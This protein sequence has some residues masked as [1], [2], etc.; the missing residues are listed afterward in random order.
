MTDPVLDRIVALQAASGNR[1]V[2]R[3]LRAGEG[4]AVPGL[5]PTSPTSSSGLPPSLNLPADYA[6]RRQAEAEA[7]IREYLDK[8]KPRVEGQIIIGASVA[9]LVDLMRRNVPEAREL[10][11]E[12]I[13]QC[14]RRYFAPLTIAEHRKPGDKEGADKELVAALRNA[15]SKIPTEL[16]IERAHGWAKVTM[17]GYEVGIRNKDLEA[18]AEVGWDKSFGGH[19]TVGNVKFAAKVSPPEEAGGPM[20]WEAQVT[21]P[22]ADDPVPIA[23][24]LSEVVSRAEK[25]THEAADRARRSGVPSM[26]ELS[27]LFSPVKEA[28]G[29]LSAIAGVSGP[30]VGVKIEGEGPKISVQATL[31]FTF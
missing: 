17:S 2:A 23:S 11:P 31:T 29:A 7:K 19:A 22:E 24:R 27:K 20:K 9:E 16:G 26:G 21:L 6:V 13:A 14:L 12:Q 3:L 18:G 15:L 5:A 25:A 10:A 28:L 4:W 30:T 1:A 8:E